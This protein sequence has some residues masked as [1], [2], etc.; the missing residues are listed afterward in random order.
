[1]KI[2]TIEWRWPEG[3]AHYVEEH[4]VRPSLAFQ[5]LITQVAEAL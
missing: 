2:G 1:M 5:M 4:N 3:F